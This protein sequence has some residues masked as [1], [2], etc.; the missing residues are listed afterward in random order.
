MHMPE[1]QRNMSSAGQ[2][3]SSQPISSELSP[4]SSCWS[5]RHVSIKQRP[6]AHVNQGH[7]GS[8]S[9]LTSRAKLLTG[10]CRVPALLLL[11][12]L[13]TPEER[14]LLLV[15]LLPTLAVRKSCSFGPPAVAEG[16]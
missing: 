13:A 3:I 11:L 10:G 4:Q 2:V 14:V 8:P 5:Q 1:A 15:L 9:D 7:A 16:E 12:L 6:L